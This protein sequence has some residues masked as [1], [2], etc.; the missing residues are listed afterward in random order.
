MP[1]TLSFLI[2]APA[3]SNARKCLIAKY[4]PSIVSVIGHRSPR[5]DGRDRARDHGVDLDARVGRRAESCRKTC[6]MRGSVGQ[7]LL[8]CLELGSAAAF[9]VLEMS[10]FAAVS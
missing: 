7:D 4:C 2:E 6:D 10:A 1:T 5:P 9:D 8:R 3:W